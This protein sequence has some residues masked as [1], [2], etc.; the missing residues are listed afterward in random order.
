[1]GKHHIMCIQLIEFDFN[2]DLLT[3]HTFM[4]PYVQCFK[5]KDSSSALLSL[6]TV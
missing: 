5:A 3:P 6:I 2:L 1:M 4:Q